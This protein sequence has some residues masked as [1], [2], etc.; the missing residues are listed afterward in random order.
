LIGDIVFTSRAR[1]DDKL[2]MLRRLPLFEDCSDQELLR[3]GH[4][5]DL[6][7]VGPGVA[8]VRRGQ[9]AW[10]VYLVMAG[11]V[12]TVGD[13]TRTEGPGTV[14]GSAEAAA[15]TA[16]PASVYTSSASELLVFNRPAFLPLAA[17]IPALDLGRGPAD[18]KR[19]H[20][21]A[22]SSSGVRPVGFEVSGRRARH[23]A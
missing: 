10:W 13:R 8:L 9:P 3:I 7:L 2:V 21:R 16:A 23:L 12:M 19:F 15:K 4:A 1:R 11:S 6:A 20:P 17:N 14:V 5:G 18:A 22:T